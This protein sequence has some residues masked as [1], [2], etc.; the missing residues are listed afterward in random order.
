MWNPTLP[1]NEGETPPLVQDQIRIFGVVFEKCG[2]KGTDHI[3][4]HVIGS[5][6]VEGG[7]CQG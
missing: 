5:G 3:D 4:L 6:P 7:L 1:K 2:D